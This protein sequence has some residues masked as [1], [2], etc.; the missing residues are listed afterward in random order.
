LKQELNMPSATTALMTF[1]ELE[2]LPD[3]SVRYELRHGEPIA[4]PP[5]K[6]KHFRIRQNLRDALA[7]TAAGSG[8]V[9]TEF[10]FRP[11]PEYEYWIADVAFASREQWL[12]IADEGNLQ[13]VPEIVIEVLSPSNTASEMLDREQVCLENGGREFWVIDPVRS[14]IKVSTADGHSVTYKRGQSIP[15]L[16]GGTLAVDSIFD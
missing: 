2:Q 1:A 10:G 7:E 5:P 15:L 12:N 16:F 11:K 13:G 8:R 14:Q 9:G 4:L 3:S 6:H